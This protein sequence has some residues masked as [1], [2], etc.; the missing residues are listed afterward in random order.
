MTLNND[1]LKQAEVYVSTLLTEKL[2]R[3]A[4][5]HNLTHTEQT[6]AATKEIGEGSSLSK[7]ELEVALVAAWFHDVGYLDV[8]EGHEERSCDIAVHFLR[9][10]NYPQPRLD[11]VLACIRATKVPQS[12]QNLLEQ[13]VCDAD[14]IHLGKKKFFERSSLLRMELELRSEETLNDLDWLLKNVEFAAA[15]NFHTDYA[16]AEF[17]G[18]REKNLITLQD[19]LREERERSEQVTAKQQKAMVKEE[20]EKKPERGIETMFRVVPKNHLDLTAL[21]DHKSNILIGTNGTIL[22]IVFSLL[23]SKL[24]THPYLLIPT[25][26]IIAVTITTMVFA[27]LATRPNVTGGTFSRE[28]IRQKKVNLLFFGNFHKSSLEDFDWGMREMMKDS[29]YL[30]GSMIK[31]L[32]FLGKVLGAKFHYLR[33]AYTIFMWGLIVAV[34]AF[35]IAMLT[36]PAPVALPVQ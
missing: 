14:M 19:L 30:Y 15:G 31:D 21:A 3:W 8:V 25:I 22:A 2:P 29:D 33:I 28:D 12:P 16:R 23:V 13:V 1:I 11:Q 4:V 20:K 17:S 7:A 35:S 6:V 34:I 18:R 24:D 9:S 36:A 32:Y 26:I 5:Y 27:I 10:R